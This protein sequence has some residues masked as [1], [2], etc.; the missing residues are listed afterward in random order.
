MRAG[1]EVLTALA[2]GETVSAE[3]QSMMERTMKTREEED[4]AQFSY[5]ISQVTERWW[6][7]N[8]SAILQ[9]I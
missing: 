5:D 7:E 8:S 3:K 4:D 1:M 6:E 2:R 9:I